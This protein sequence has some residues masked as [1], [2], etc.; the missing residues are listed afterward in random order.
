M[1]IKDF[2]LRLGERKAEDYFFGDFLGDS[3]K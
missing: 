3:I 1:A 2:L